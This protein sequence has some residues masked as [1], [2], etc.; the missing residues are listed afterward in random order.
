MNMTKLEQ[1]RLNDFKKVLAYHIASKI[2]YHFKGNYKLYYEAPIIW[3][4]WTNGTLKY[5]KKI[6]ELIIKFNQTSLS[7]HQVQSI[8]GKTGEGRWMN[9]G[10]L[11]AKDIE[12]RT[13]N[14]GTICIK[15][16]T[17]GKQRRFQIKKRYQLPFEYIKAI[18]E[19]SK[20]LSKVLDAGSEFYTDRQRRLI[21]TQI[22]DKKKN[23]HYKTNKQ[24][25]DEMTDQEKVDALFAEMEKE[26]NNDEKYIR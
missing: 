20:L 22:N 14:K 25:V 15:D 6:Y 12:I 2:R 18:F 5:D 13:F 19:D 3:K 21:F 24:L 7:A 23:Y 1:E 16:K 8:F 10:T 11:I 4:K 9:Y 17:T 26:E